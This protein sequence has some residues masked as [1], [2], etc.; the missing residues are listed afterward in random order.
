MSSHPPVHDSAHDDLL[1]AHLAGDVPAGD[2]TLTQRLGQCGECRA[3]L[4]ELNALTGLLDR[5]GDGQRRSLRPD[6][7][8][9]A[10][11]ADRVAATL[12]A[13][14]A[15]R[16]P[17][18]VARSLTT[19]RVTL[20]RVGLA[21]ASVLAAGW[22]VRAL[23]PP[24]E[25]PR[26]DVLLGDGSKATFMPMGE[27]D[28]FSPFAWPGLSP[29][30]N[31]IYLTVWRLEDGVRVLVFDD[32]IPELYW[33]PTPDQLHAMGQSIEW[34]LRLVNPAGITEAMEAGQASLRR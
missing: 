19:R 33:V 4:A 1:H 27:V 20:W 7:L 17:A 15:G 22:I 2:P 13:L 29:D 21:A 31:Q 6:A 18:S 30:A 26:E 23:L 25:S 5:V 14:A 11:G 3:R 32:T 34:E 16:E 8:Q 24:D 9:T 10:P 28:S 12:H